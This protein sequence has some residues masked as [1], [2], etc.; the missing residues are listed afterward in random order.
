MHGLSQEVSTSS[1]R[2]QIR[3]AFPLSETEEARS[4][5]D[6]HSLVGA[7]SSILKLENIFLN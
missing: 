1:Q 6:H 5:T 7:I 4:A 2:G 3:E